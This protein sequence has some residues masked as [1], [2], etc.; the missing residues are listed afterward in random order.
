[1]RPQLKSLCLLAGAALLFCGCAGADRR[2]GRGLNNLTEPIRMGELRREYE[3]AAI[4][5]GADSRTVGLVRGIHRTVKRTVIG[6]F[7]VVTFPLGGD[8]IMKPVGPVYPDS[9]KPRLPAASSLQTDN[10]LGFSG[11]D[12]APTLPG[13]RFRVFE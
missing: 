6:A 1:M 3:Q 12:V 5:T 4:F 2:L 13:S 9:Y 8:P 10:N 7:E 11:G